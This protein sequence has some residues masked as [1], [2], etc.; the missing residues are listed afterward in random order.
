MTSIEF[1]FWLLRQYVFHILLNIL[2]NKNSTSLIT[3]LTIFSFNLNLFSANKYV[4][5]KIV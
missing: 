5:H 4:S 1:Y 3:Y 2:L